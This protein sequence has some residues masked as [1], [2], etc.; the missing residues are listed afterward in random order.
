M[1]SPGA[2]GTDSAARAATCGCVKCCECVEKRQTWGGA[3]KSSAGLLPTWRWSAT[4][5]VWSCWCRA[6]GWCQQAASGGA[7]RSSD[8][9][10]QESGG[11]DTVCCPHMLPRPPIC[12]HVGAGGQD[13]SDHSHILSGGWGFGGKT[14]ACASNRRAAAAAGVYM[15]GGQPHPLCKVCTYRLYTGQVTD[16][17]RSESVALAPPQQCFGGKP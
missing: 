10:R 6:G 17:A 4:G 11:G 12:C 13:N 16:G 3:S 9:Q 15:C 5:C 8:H 14:T 1:W 7:A 2:L